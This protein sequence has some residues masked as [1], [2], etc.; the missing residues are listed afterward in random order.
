VTELKIGYARVS[1]T[2]HQDLTAQRDALASL[3]VDPDPVRKPT[4]SS[5]TA[6]ANTP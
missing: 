4:S 1:T 3:G 5:S 2:D 6:P